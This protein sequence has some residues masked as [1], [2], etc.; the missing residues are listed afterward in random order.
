MTDEPKGRVIWADGPPPDGAD[1]NGWWMSIIVAPSSYGIGA[2]GG[3]MNSIIIPN[4]SPA[5]RG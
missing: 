1:G 3:P 5:M 4:K 2:D